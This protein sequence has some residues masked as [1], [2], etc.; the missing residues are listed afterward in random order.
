MAPTTATADADEPLLP[1]ALPLILGAVALIGL[2]GIML[3]LHLLRWMR[4][5]EWPT[6]L[7][8][9]LLSSLG[10]GWPATSWRGVQKIVDWVM[11]SLAAGTVF[12]TGMATFWIGALR[13]SA[14]EA[15]T[16]AIRNAKINRENAAAIAA[17]DA[18]YAA[19]AAKAEA[20]RQAE[21]G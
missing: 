3:L 17:R 20:R 12:W 14:E 4:E 11:M 15:R 13:N 1:I 21:E 16:A 2:S 18:R 10:F 7:T 19:N 6:Y 5:G 9:N 8:I